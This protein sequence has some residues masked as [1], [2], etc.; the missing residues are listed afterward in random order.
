MYSSKFKEGIESKY[1]SKFIWSDSNNSGINTIVRF[2]IYFPY[3]SL[4]KRSATEKKARKFNII[5]TEK[6]L[7]NDSK[8][9][10]SIRIFKK[11]FS[12]NLTLELKFLNSKF[13]IEKT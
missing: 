5:S 13:K 11:S 1:W 7:I 10:Y 12:R 2:S 8:A 9:K 6:V 3:K 4:K